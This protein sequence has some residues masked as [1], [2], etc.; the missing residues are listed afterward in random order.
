GSTIAIF[1]FGISGTALLVGVV[2]ALLGAAASYGLAKLDEKYSRE[3]L[4]S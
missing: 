2:L 4:F 3:D 1:P